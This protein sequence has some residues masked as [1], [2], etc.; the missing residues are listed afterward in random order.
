M[1]GDVPFF[2]KT[3]MEH[4]SREMQ[5]GEE[6]KKKETNEIL[7]HPSPPLPPDPRNPLFSL[8]YIALFCS[9]VIPSSFCPVVFLLFRISK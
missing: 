9:R 8:A 5:G 4:L 6:E 1:C 2:C 3:S 7:P